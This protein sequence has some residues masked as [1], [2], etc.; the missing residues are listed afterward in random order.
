MQCRALQDEA[1]TCIFNRVLL[2]VGVQRGEH[3]LLLLIK[4][5]YGRELLKFSL[6]IYV[7]DLQQAAM[8]SSSDRS[9][10]S[11]AEA[12]QEQVHLLHIF[13]AALLPFIVRP[14][15]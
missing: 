1:S 6:P 7:Q 2:Q 12:M 14:M 5:I 3:E 4:Q 9:T 11:V 15:L 10:I 8:P 13:Y